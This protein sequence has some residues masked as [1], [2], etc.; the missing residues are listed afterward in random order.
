MRLPFTADQFF[1]VFRQY[2]EAVWPA[3]LLL[4]LLAVALLA[5]AVLNHP[6]HPR[7]VP[8][9]L[10]ALWLWMGAAYHLTFFAEVNPAAFLFGALFLVQGLLFAWLAVRETTF[11][12]SPRSSAGGVAG[13][14]LVLYALVVYPAL[15]LMLGHAYPASPTFGLPCPTTIFT[16]GVLL[17]AR[18]FLPWR[19]LVIPMGWTIVGGVAALQLGVWEDLGLVVAAMI[20]AGRVFDRHALP[21][22]RVAPHAL[23]R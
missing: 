8:A 7:L 10:A 23:M 4:T 6:R 18:P 19:L 9:I 22:D 13:W 16:L 14:A 2:N 5:L 21:A 1:E 20:V 3:Q 17:W 15:G 11:T 12:F